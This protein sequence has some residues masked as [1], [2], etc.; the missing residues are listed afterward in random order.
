MSRLHQTGNARMRTIAIHRS[1]VE[2]ANC[3]AHTVTEARS[4]GTLATRT[5]AR[6]ATRLC[7]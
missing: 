4:G 5:D 3:V 7:L 2:N 6:Y 1:G